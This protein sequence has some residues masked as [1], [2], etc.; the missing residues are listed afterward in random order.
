MLMLELRRK[1]ATTKMSEV[2]D[3]YLNGI[4]VAIKKPVREDVLKILRFIKEAKYWQE[5]SDLGIGGVP[6]VIGINEEEPWFAV[7]FIEGETLDAY[8]RSADIR[9]IMHRMMEVLSI[10]HAV[11]RAG[12]LHLD[13]K[14]SNIIIDK[15]GDIFFLDWGLAAQIFRKLKD[16]VYTFVGTPSY[17]PPEMW[18]PDKYGKPDPR[19][20]VYEVG[21]TFYRVIAKQVPFTKKSEVLNGEIKPFPKTTPAAVKKIIL[22]AINQDK[23]KR[24]KDAMDMYKDVQRWMTSTRVLWRGV[25][26]IKFKKTLQIHYSNNFS[27]VSDPPQKGNRR[28]FGFISEQS[29]TKNLIIK[30]IDKKMKAYRDG[31]FVI[32]GKKEKVKANTIAALYQG[33]VIYYKKEDIGKLDYG[34]RNLVNVDFVSESIEAAKKYFE[35]LYFL[36]EEGIKYKIKRGED[37]LNILAHK[38]LIKNQA[39]DEEVDALLRIGD[40][41]IHLRLMP[42]IPYDS[43]MTIYKGDKD[44][45]ELLKEILGC[46]V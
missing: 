16:D 40:R 3:G 39:P 35:F 15:Y 36:K 21:T 37:K 24:Y 12:Y 6:K 45:K 7:E 19:S 25:H 32:R 28:T 5:I 22:K 10:L 43:D 33:T 11:H 31:V 27:F 23:S 14:P 18:D 34:F 20:D 8:L 17:A 9:E 13:I 46:E 4:R 1:I 42:H 2:W 41:R 30:I 29:K 38:V 44:N 26:Q